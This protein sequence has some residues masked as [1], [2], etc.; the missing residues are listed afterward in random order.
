[1][2]SKQEKNLTMA[3][4]NMDIGKLFI[5]NNILNKPEKLT[6][7]ENKIMMTHPVLSV[8]KLKKA[9]VANPKMLSI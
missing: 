3:A 2:T 4:L 1:M 8:A 9:N 6:D 7:D 5:P